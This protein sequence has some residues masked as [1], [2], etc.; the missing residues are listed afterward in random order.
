MSMHQD[1]DMAGFVEPG[2]R[3]VTLIYIL[4]LVGFVIGFTSLIGLVFA[5]LNR[6]R[7][8]G[9][10]TSHYTFQIRTFWIALLYGLVC[11]V[12]A[13][14]G[15]GFVLMILVAIWVIVRCVKGLQ[16]AS[17]QQPIADPQTWLF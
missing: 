13:F 2:G 14:I 5:Y 15:I 10:T 4:Y 11:L 1:T 17:R 3:N 6:G 7:S 9:W 8:Q 16:A 12:L